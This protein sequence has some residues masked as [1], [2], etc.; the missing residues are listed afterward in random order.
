MRNRLHK[1]TIACALRVTEFA[2]G[3]TVAL[4]F[5]ERGQMKSY[6]L[7]SHPGV[8]IEAVH[9]AN[10]C[11]C[12]AMLDM[13]VVHYR[14]DKFEVSDVLG[15]LSLVWARVEEKNA[16]FEARTKDRENAEPIEPHQRLWTLA[17][18]AIDEY[19]VV[20]AIRIEGKRPCFTVD[21]MDRLTIHHVH[22][23]NWV[24]WRN[25]VGKHPLYFDL[26]LH[27]CDGTTQ[28]SYVTVFRILR[29][30]DRVQVETHNTVASYIEEYRHAREQHP[31]TAYDRSH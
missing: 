23:G 6:T 15:D 21:N 8:S 20:Q 3:H 10:R 2:T 17:Q 30:S 7:E 27:F 29:R 24:R 5:N 31:P 19:E 9:A 22:F 1:P 4:G 28:H 13:E 26:P 18:R 16:S 25:V 11:G 14:A 12:F